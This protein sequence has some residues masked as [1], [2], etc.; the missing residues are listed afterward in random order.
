MTQSDPGITLATLVGCPDGRIYTIES[1]DS[2][3]LP[4]NRSSHNVVRRLESDGTLTLL[5]YDFSFDGLAADCDPA[6]GRII[7]TSG[8]GIFALAPP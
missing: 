7:F 6:T 8:A 2:S 4:V 1:L 3:N 5:G